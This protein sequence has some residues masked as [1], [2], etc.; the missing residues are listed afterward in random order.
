MEKHISL[1]E[2]ISEKPFRY[3]KKMIALNIKSV[4]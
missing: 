3:L 1:I 2:A 4:S